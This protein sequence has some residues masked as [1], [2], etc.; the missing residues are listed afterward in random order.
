[1]LQQHACGLRAAGRPA[2]KAALLPVTR[3]AKA[4][5]C[6]TRCAVSNRDFECARIDG[7][8]SAGSASRMFTRASR[9]APSPRAP[10]PQAS[11]A[12]RAAGASGA[13]AERNGV[14]E[15]AA[16][17]AGACVRGG[18]GST[19]TWMGGRGP[20][21]GWH[22]SRVRV[23]RV[24]RPRSRPRDLGCSRGGVDM[25]AVPPARR[26]VRKAAACRRRR[27]CTLDPA[28]RDDGAAAAGRGVGRRARQRRRGREAQGAAGAPRGRRRGGGAGVSAGSTGQR[29]S[30]GRGCTFAAAGPA[31]LL[32]AGQ[33]LAPLTLTPPNR[34]RAP[35]RRRPTRRRRPR[36][37]SARPRRAPRPASPARRPP[38][39]RRR[40]D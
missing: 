25:R 35:A 20:R 33:P 27:C 32:A 2:V 9:R 19:R 40:R 3:L 13:P 8:S 11:R 16:Q 29:P 36:T 23:C 6:G 12:V 24:P 5:G 18:M 4:R 28:G 37:P 15:R 17:V 34:R 10:R 38:R 31:S 1:M 39:R 7:R 26:P 14:L 21:G 22:A 30:R